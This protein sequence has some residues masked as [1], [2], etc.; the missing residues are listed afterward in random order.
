MDSELMKN[1]RKLV[2]SLL[3]CAGFIS[4][5]LLLQLLVRVIFPYRGSLRVRQIPSVHCLVL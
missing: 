1:N 5:I 4:G 2:M 3:L